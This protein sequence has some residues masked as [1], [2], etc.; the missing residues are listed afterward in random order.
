MAINDK[1]SKLRVASITYT[2]THDNA[3][4][5]DEQ[6]DQTD[7]DDYETKDESGDDDNDDDDDV[8]DV[9][10]YAQR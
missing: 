6:T 2:D 9:D 5:G 1:S 4:A 8:D 7:E 3:A 10:I